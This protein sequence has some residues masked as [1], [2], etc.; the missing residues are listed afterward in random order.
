MPTED[1]QLHTS[2]CCFAP[3]LKDQ[4]PALQS[5][6]DRQ[7]CMKLGI[8]T[9]CS[10]C[11]RHIVLDAKWSYSILPEQQFHGLFFSPGIIK[12]DIRMLICS[13]DWCLRKIRR[14]SLKRVMSTRP[15]HG[16]SIRRHNR[17]FKPYNICA[18]ASN[19]SCSFYVYRG[20]GVIG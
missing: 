19:K 18:I 13:I 1:L 5:E 9:S 8:V 2:S 6:D 14:F 17:N 11:T 7:G 4:T 3:S 12:T 15:F 16:R 20:K 10:Q